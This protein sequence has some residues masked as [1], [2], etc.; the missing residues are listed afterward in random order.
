M[1]SRKGTRGYFSLRSNNNNKRFISLLWSVFIS[2]YAF[3]I[4]RGA[5]RKGNKEQ[6]RV[7]FSRLWS[8]VYRAILADMG[9]GWKTKVTGKGGGERKGG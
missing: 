7:W 2:S 5:K 8:N 3:C 4:G 1:L 6:K 9:R